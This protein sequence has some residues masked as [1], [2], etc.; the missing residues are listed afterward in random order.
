MSYIYI[1]KLS[2]IVK[3]YLKKKKK[4]DLAEI[5]TF[6]CTSSALNSIQYKPPPQ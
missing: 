6:Y 4:E 1:Y 5:K 3:Y 2:K